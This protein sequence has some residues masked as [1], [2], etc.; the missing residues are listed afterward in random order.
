MLSRMYFFLKSVDFCLQHWKQTN[1]QTKPHC[2]AMYIITVLHTADG[3]YLGEW[4]IVCRASSQPLASSITSSSSC[5]FFT[6]PPNFN[7]FSQQMNGTRKSSCKLIGTR[8]PL[9]KLLVLVK[10]NTVTGRKGI[11]ISRTSFS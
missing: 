1:K 3:S 2:L 7:C 8:K 9:L 5:C 6:L 4:K 10:T 11:R